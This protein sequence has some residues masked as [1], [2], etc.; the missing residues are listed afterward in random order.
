M[1]CVANLVL[2]SQFSVVNWVFIFTKHKQISG[3]G[4]LIIRSC[5]N[6]LVN[7]E[8][9]LFVEISGF[10]SRDVCSSFFSESDILAQKKTP[11]KIYI[12]F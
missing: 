8:R 6:F 1:I 7:F 11:L 2:S 12:N 4:S 10:I 3:N 9:G 5:L